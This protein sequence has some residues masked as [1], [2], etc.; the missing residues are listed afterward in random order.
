MV[1]PRHNH[2]A[3]LLPNGKVLVSAAGDGPTPPLTAEVYDPASGTWS[4]AASMTTVRY[5]H[6][7]TALPSS[8]VLVTGG[9]NG[10]SLASAELYTP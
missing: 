1:S 4:V 9:W 7:A 3:T 2:E 10:A 8:Q 6:T 5:S